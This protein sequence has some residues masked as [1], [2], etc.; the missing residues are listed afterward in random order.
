[1][2]SLR[3]AHFGTETQLQEPRRLQDRFRSTKTCVVPPS[4]CWP[5][6]RAV[7]P[8]LPR[9]RRV[10]PAAASLCRAGVGLRSRAGESLDSWG[11]VVVCGA[12]VARTCLAERPWAPR[13]LSRNVFDQVTGYVAGAP[14]GVSTATIRRSAANP[15]VWFLSV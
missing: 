4:P 12:I 3:Q 6:P 9:N 13:L 5:C 14:A 10:F 1:L 11:Y 2:T 8:S 15:P 7:C